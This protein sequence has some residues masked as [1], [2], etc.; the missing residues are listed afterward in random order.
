MACFFLAAGCTHLLETLSFAVRT[1]LASFT[2]HDQLEPVKLVG[3]AASTVLRHKSRFLPASPSVELDRF[4]RSSWRAV[5]I[6]RGLESSLSAS[7]SPTNLIILNGRVAPG[8]AGLLR[9]VP[10]GY[11]ERSTERGRAYSEEC[12]SIVSK[13]LHKR[14]GA[15]AAVSAFGARNSCRRVDPTAVMAAAAA[16]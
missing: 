5:V 10:N 13:S 4:K 12:L 11:A 1:Q 6:A 15:G 14:D 3:L 16:T 2:A 8:L 9:P 7:S